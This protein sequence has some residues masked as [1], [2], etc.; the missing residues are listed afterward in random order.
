MAG[1][2]PTVWECS[3]DVYILGI[4]MVQEAA[5]FFL[6]R[7][8]MAAGR[9]FRPRQVS[10]MAEQREREWGGKTSDADQG[11]YCLIRCR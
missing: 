3:F 10:S 7:F 8:Y 11:I 2:I 9:V 5:A 6:G 1:L 4:K